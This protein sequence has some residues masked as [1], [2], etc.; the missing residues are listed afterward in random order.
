MPSSST[1]VLSA[2]Q[3]R[4]DLHLQQ[5]PRLRVERRLGQHLGVHLAQAL[6]PR[7]LRLRVRPQPGEDLFLVL[8]V[9]GPVRLLADV[10]AVQR[11]LGDVDVPLADQLRHVAEEEVEQ[12]RRDVVAVGVGVHQQ[13]DLAVAQ[14]VDS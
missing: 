12:Q 14:A 13:D 1:N 3:V 6:E 4:V 9:A 2:S 8:V 10:D 5:R 7:D 11:R